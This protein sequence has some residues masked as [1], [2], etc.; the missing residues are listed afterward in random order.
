[1]DNNQEASRAV[2]ITTKSEKVNS[3]VADLASGIGKK[4][5]IA[6]EWSVLAYKI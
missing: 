4:A 1:M 5:K 6:M 2:Q 3:P